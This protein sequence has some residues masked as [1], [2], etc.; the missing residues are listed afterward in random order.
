M[1]DR[2]VHDGFADA[3]TIK[4]PFEFYE[5]L[6]NEA[7]V[8]Y[9]PALCGYVVSR[10]E[11][12]RTVLSNDKVFS[13]APRIKQV[14][15][16]AKFAEKY[17]PLYAAAGTPPPLPTL[18]VVDGDKH[19]RHRQ[20]V[21]GWFNAP[22]VRKLDPAIT[23]LVDRLIEGFI[24]RGRVDI[25]EEFCLRLP[26]FVICDMLGLPRDGASIMHR[27]GAAQI[28][29]VSGGAETEQ[30]RIDCHRVI[31]EFQQ[32]L[33]PYI[34]AARLHPADHL[35]SHLVNTTTKDGDK[36]SDREIHS[37][38]QSLNAGGT[39][40]TTNGLGNMLGLMLEHPK[41]QEALRA[42][43]ALIPRFVDEVIRI[44]SPVA[45]PP[46]WTNVD[47]EIS[48]VRIPAESMVIARIAA[49]NRDERRFQCPANPD[50]NRSGLRNHVGFG[51]GV[52]YCL[53]AALARFEMKAALERILARMNDI[54]LD[55]DAPAPT[56]TTKI[57]IRG[58]TSL[59]IL[60]EK[61]G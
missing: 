43:P 39:E 9:S 22:A 15:A 35:L 11:D 2:A 8:F 50:F 31:I 25:Y 59:P 1:S 53:G 55:P 61:I 52:H 51:A 30:G 40:T 23:E 45:G 44:D 41:V 19:T 38:V 16:M 27:T 29:L 12:V 5:L 3:A 10:F 56:R 18:V 14:S 36:L 4:Q 47:T 24:D 49:A 48:G 32:F 46:R 7:P 34:D 60:F 13:S 28:R 6:R 57:S 21:D 20:L 54:R 26:L 17:F 37:L 42:D 58:W 33:Q